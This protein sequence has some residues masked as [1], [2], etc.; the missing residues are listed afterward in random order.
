[1]VGRSPNID[2][3]ESNIICFSANCSILGVGLAATAGE[4]IVC[5]LNNSDSSTLQAFVVLPPRRNDG[6]AK[7]D[8]VVGGLGLIVVVEAEDLEGD[9]LP[10]AWAKTRWI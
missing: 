5:S 7:G 10:C 8:S 6:V 1:M 2:R 3:G 9:L 4:K